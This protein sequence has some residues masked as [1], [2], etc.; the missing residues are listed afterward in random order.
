MATEIVIVD[1]QE[2][3]RL[4]FRLVLG[5]QPDL[6]VTGEGADGIDAIELARRLRPDVMVMDI[7]M[8]RLD[9]VEATR[10]IMAEDPGARVIL[11]TT[12]NAQEHAAAAA[13]AGARE[14]LLKDVA[15]AA[16]LAAI[17]AVAR[18]PAPATGSPAP[19]SPDPRPCDTSA[20]T[21]GGR[22]A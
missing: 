13:Q 21:P 4:S 7:R 9:G 18:S 22:R 8:P 5:S 12:F 16:L 20:A 19:R 6:R 14:L 17:R 2:L 15:P 3:M 1:D 11:L 10:R